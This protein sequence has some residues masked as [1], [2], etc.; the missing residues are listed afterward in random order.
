VG[1][2]CAQPEKA[3]GF[4][5][6]P[7][8]RREHG[9][10]KAEKIQTV[11]HHPLRLLQA[12]F[13]QDVRRVHEGEDG[14]AEDG[15]AQLPVSDRLRSVEDPVPTAGVTVVVVEVNCRDRGCGV[16][17]G[18]VQPARVED[19]DLHLGSMGG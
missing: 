1:Q 11:P 12:A 2:A 18:I 13:A 17:D 4:A 9:V 19:S 14:I 10:S 7:E 6:S 15:I 3:H 16:D 8:G 5:E